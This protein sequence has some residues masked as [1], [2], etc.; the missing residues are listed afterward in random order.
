[1]QLEIVD[2]ASA[3]SQGTAGG[4]V[5]CAK[6]PEVQNFEA[7]ESGLY[8]LGLS[9][10]ATLLPSARNQKVGI[11]VMSSNAWAVTY[12]AGLML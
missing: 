10:V 6:W 12:G 8:G 11:S 4:G 3:R 2:S 1:M 7:N 5:G 9:V